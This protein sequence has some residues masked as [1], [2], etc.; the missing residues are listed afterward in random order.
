MGANRQE[1]ER[2]NFLFLQPVGAQAA[3]DPALRGGDHVLRVLLHEAH[4]GR[5]FARGILVQAE[6]ELVGLGLDFV[7]PP[8]MHKHFR[9]SRD[10]DSIH[11]EALM[12]YLPVLVQVT[13]GGGCCSLEYTRA[14]TRPLRNGTWSAYRPAVSPCES[15]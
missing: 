12:A 3:M 2:T 8:R 6:A 11:L 13:E 4:H 14:R 10:R 5:V 1:V 15:L 7:A 9:F